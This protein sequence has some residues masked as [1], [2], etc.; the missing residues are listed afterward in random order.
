MQLNTVSSGAYDITAGLWGYKT[1]CISVNIGTQGSF[2][3]AI[4]QGIFDDFT[5]DYGWTTSGTA[6]TGMWVREEPVGTF[7]SS[8]PA[9]PELDVTND[10]S[11]RCFITGNGGGGANN[12]DVDDGY[13][14]L[15]SPVFDLTGFTDPYLH[16]ERW[17]YEQFSSNPAGND[18]MFVYMTNGTV[19][20][21]VDVITGPSATNSSWV[22]NS[23]PVLNF[24]SLSSTMQVIVEISDK[25]GTGNPLECGFDR[26]EVTEG[27]T[28]LTD[29]GAF[30]DELGIYPNPATDFATLTL[31]TDLSGIPVQVSVKDISGREMYAFAAVTA[32]ELRIETRS[33][34]HGV[35]FITVTAPSGRMYGAKLVR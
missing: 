29:A 8:T 14:M 7:F 23:L 9:N 3:L 30:L 5:F 22:P 12:D 17:F 16:Y 27:P 33:W 19:T 32:N 35:Y 25:V 11:D 6:P 18:T 15:T 34:S 2:T 13:V 28:G 4:D 10:C 24:L 21:A 26:F 1:S 31:P 20:V